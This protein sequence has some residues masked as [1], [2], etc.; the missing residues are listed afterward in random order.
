M[1][2]TPVGAMTSQVNILQVQKRRDASG[3]FLQPMDVFAG[4]MWAYIQFKADTIKEKSEQVVTE[5]THKIVIRYFPG[6]T[7]AMVVQDISNDPTGKV[8]KLY[9]LATSPI[10]PDGKMMELWLM[11]YERDD[12]SRGVQV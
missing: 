10:D 7:S 6:I 11:C 5:S 8:G 3:E 1:S 4:P 12:G 2:Y 9:N